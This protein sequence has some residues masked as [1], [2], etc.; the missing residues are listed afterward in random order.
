MFRSRSRASASTSNELPVE[1]AVRVRKVE[2]IEAYNVGTKP[3][4]TARATAK[5]T[6]S[7]TVSVARVGD[8]DEKADTFVSVPISDN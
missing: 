2:R 7:M 5:M 1:G 4:A 6:R 3:P 8:V